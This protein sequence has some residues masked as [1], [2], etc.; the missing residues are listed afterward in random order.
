[1]TF[2]II[3]RDEKTGRVGIAV[4]SK[5]L[6]VG[7]RNAFI[8]TGVGAVASQALFNP[9]YGPRGLAVM[10][11]GASAEDAVRL[12]TAADEG[13]EV[14]QLHAMDRAGK[15][16]A[17]TGSATPQWSGHL[18]RKSFSVAGNALAG[19]QVIEAV[20]TAYQYHAALPFARRLIAAMTAGEQAGGD[21]RGRQSAA[22]LVHDEEEYSLLDL[23]VD[24]HVDPLAELARLEGVAR[25]SWIHFR[26]VLANRKEPHGV[27]DLGAADTRIADSIKDGYE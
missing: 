4:A 16:A 7:A 6:A 27:L 12:L 2:S 8:K 26:R 23:R 14:R 10:G 20:A 5:F 3:A 21:K 19:P 13:R 9:H 24:D 25:Q 22:L 1:M 11:A 18:L 17:F 15:F